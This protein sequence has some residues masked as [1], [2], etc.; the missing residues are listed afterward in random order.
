MTPTEFAAK[1]RLHP[2]ATIRVGRLTDREK[3][4]GDAKTKFSGL[5]PHYAAQGCPLVEWS[6]NKPMAESNGAQIEFHFE[7]DLAASFPGFDKGSWIPY[8]GLRKGTL[9]QLTY[10]KLGMAPTTSAYQVLREAGMILNKLKTA[11]K[12]VFL[13]S[14]PWLSPGAMGAIVGRFH[15]LGFFSL[16]GEPLFI[17]PEAIDNGVFQADWPADQKERSIVGSLAAQAAAQAETSW[18]EDLKGV[19]LS[20]NGKAKGAELHK[21]ILNA[22]ASQL[23]Q[24]GLA[25]DLPTALITATAEAPAAQAAPAPAPAPEPKKVAPKPTQASS[26]GTS[27]KKLLGRK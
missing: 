19:V 1:I 7:E 8:N 13:V 22:R 24:R 26:R 9:V 12:K 16:E 25:P 17:S 2:C 3:T 11:G 23:V 27:G 15:L 5:T 10:G 21:A 18:Y 14:Y 4:T 6:G 20:I